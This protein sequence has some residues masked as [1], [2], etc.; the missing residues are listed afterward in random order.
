MNDMPEQPLE[1]QPSGAWEWFESA[2]KYASRLFV[3]EE[4]QAGIIPD[5]MKYNWFK[6]TL[7]ENLRDES[8]YDLKYWWENNGQPGSFDDVK[9]S[10]FF[11]E[12][13]GVWHASSVDPV[14]HRFLKTDTHPTV[15]KEIGW[16]KSN[17]PE[18][19]KYREAY[20]L[21]KKGRFW[22]YVAHD[23]PVSAQARKNADH[24]ISLLR[25]QGLTDKAIA[26]VM[27][28]IAVE[29]G[30][31]YTY[32]KRQKGGSGYGLLQFDREHKDAYLKYIQ[33]NR[34]KDSPEAQME[35]FHESIYGS[36]RGVTGAGNA[37]VLG[38]LFKDPNAS[39]KELHEEFQLRYMHTGKPHPDRRDSAID[40]WDLKFRKLI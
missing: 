20:S 39:T 29:T 33:K 4:A 31:D 10:G 8:G 38:K 5:W 15:Q 12:V 26:V 27:G 34:L 21:V 17:D 37:G 24:V 19:V 16:Y 30:G 40:Y 14:T 2:Q 11:K 35:Y 3:G 25:G 7:P 22:Q 32:T 6:M 1:D 36:Q 9:G 28:N 18:A 13:N 23:A